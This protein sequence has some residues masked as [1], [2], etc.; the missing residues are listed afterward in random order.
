MNLS[1]KC[2][3]NGGAFAFLVHFKLHKSSIYTPLIRAINFL[4][5]GILRLNVIEFKKYI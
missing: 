5:L 2:S 4:F 3:A 1:W